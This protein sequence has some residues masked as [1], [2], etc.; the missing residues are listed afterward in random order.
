MNK[1]EARYAGHLETQRRAGEIVFWRYES[2]KFRLADRTWYT[3]DFYLMRPDG[4][5]EVHEAKGW[6]QDD[7]NVKIKSVA[8]QFPELVFVLVKWEKGAWGYK[9]YREVNK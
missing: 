8:E 4:C 9:R 1:L 2:L 5:L 6:M 7:A 3:P